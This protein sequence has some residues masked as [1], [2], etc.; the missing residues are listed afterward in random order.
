MK[1]RSCR[2][3]LLA[4]SLVLSCATAMGQAGFPD[5]P[6]RIVV[7]F[8]PGGGTDVLAR[9][10]AQQMSALARVGRWARRWWPRP[11][12][13]ATHSMWAPPRPP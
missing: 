1:P 13:T 3:L 5:K 11:L 8:A 2:R 7:P 4:M 9:I 6:I 12:P 10:V